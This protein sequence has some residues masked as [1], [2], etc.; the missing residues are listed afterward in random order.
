MAESPITARSQD[1]ATWYQDVVLQGDMAEPAEIVKG[2]MV[3]KANG[4]AIANQVEQVV[5][6]TVSADECHK[7]VAL[8]VDKLDRM[9][10]KRNSLKKVK[11][12][13]PHAIEFLRAA[14]GVHGDQPCD[15]VGGRLTREEPRAPIVAAVD[16]A[17]SGIEYLR[18]GARW[19]GRA[20][21]RSR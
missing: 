5:N 18:F 16:V 12:N 10:A 3:I 8:L 4:Y 7:A 13:H 21:I 15:L 14:A 9:L 11:R 17:I 20:R 2:C 6:A 1:F 19:R